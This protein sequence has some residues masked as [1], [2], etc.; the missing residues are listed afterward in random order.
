LTVI[1]ATHSLGF[2]AAALSLVYW[3]P[4]NGERFNVHPEGL[5]KYGPSGAQQVSIKEIFGLKN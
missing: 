5:R 1:S 3:G 4:K 2:K